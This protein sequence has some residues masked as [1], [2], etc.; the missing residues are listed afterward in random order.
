MPFFRVQTLVMPNLAFGAPEEMYARLSGVTCRCSLEKKI[1]YLDKGD[2][3]AFDTFFNALTIHN[4]KRHCRIEDLS[5]ALTGHGRFRLRFGLHRIGHAHRWIDEREIDLTKGRDIRLELP[6]WKELN[7]GLLYFALLALDDGARLIGGCYGTETSP[8]RDVHLGIVITHF[9]RRDYV[10][11]AVDRIKSELLDDPAFAKT[12]EVIVVDNSCNIS[13]GEVAG[14]TLIPNQNFGGSGGFMRGLLHLEDARTF[15]H[16]LFM[17]DDAHF[18]I[19]SIRRTFALLSYSKTPKFAVAGALL[20]ET[21]PHRLFE[22]GAVFE[23]LCRPL[24]RGL[25]VRRVNDLLNAEQ[26]N[27]VPHYGGWWLFGFA[28]TDVKSYAFPFFVRGD[29]ILFSLM[30]RFNICTMNGVACWGEDFALKSGPTALY[31]DARNHLLIALTLLEKKRKS[32][33]HFI[34]RFFEKQAYSYCYASAAAISLALEHVCQGPQFW[35]DNLDMSAVCAQ[36]AAIPSEENM[37]PIDPAKL[38]VAYYRKRRRRLDRVLQ[39]LS[40]N[41]MLIPGRFLKRRI[42]FQRKG[43]VGKLHQIYQYRRVCYEYTALGTGFVATHDKTRLCYEY[44]VFLKR[45]YRFF[46]SFKALR[47]NYRQ[48]LPELTSRQFWEEVLQI[49]QISSTSNSSHSCAEDAE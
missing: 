6:F 36:I 26:V 29:D 21:K 4:W 12:I 33:M 41:G 15:T 14:A 49:T 38:K 3:V 46:R 19:E 24:K 13:P 10:L 7:N 16:C 22:K 44:W 1:L 45:L 23:G 2:G 28:L 34:R 11:P 47:E 8:E 20:R 40:L 27:E 37:A 25:D 32:T 39:K 9:N 31:L 5:L 30:N 35:R 18:E 42:I 48:A 43:F 17:D